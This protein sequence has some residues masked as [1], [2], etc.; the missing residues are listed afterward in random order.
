MPLCIMLSLFV[1]SLSESLSHPPL[2][3]RLLSSPIYFNSWLSLATLKTLLEVV[4][5][6]VLT[7]GFEGGHLIVFKVR[8]YFIRLAA[9]SM[10][11]SL[12]REQEGWDWFLHNP[13]EMYD[14]M[15]RP[16]STV[17]TVLQP[18]QYGSRQYQPVPSRLNHINERWY[19]MPV[20]IRHGAQPY[21]SRGI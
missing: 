13:P 11:P 2:F 6:A 4:Q 20:G 5:I 12:R 21:M 1:G 19:R 18:S 14:G 17:H 15:Q 16:Y 3:L 9:L 8:S 7:V 10:G